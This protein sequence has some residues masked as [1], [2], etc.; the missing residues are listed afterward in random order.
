MIQIIVIWRVLS[1]EKKNIFI[2]NASWI[3][4]TGTSI[5]VRIGFGCEQRWARSVG[6]RRRTDA[7]LRPP[8]RPLRH[9]RL[10]CWWR[11]HL[12]RIPILG[13]RWAAAGAIPWC[14]QLAVT[15]S[16][17]RRHQHTKKRGK[18]KKNR[19]VMP[20]IHQKLFV[21]EIGSTSTNRKR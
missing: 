8:W 16:Q 17:K 4:A 13:A 15:K 12:R 2:A 21:P 9:N 5:D 20:S 1:G 3:C 11:L 18:K 14:V 6:W 19:R 7:S 10:V